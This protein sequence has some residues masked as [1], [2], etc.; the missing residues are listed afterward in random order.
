MAFHNVKKP[1]KPVENWF[2][3]TSNLGSWVRQAAPSGTGSAICF[4]QT[5]RYFSDRLFFQTG[6]KES[7]SD[8]RDPALRIRQ[9]PGTRHFGPGNV[10]GPGTSDPAIARHLADLIKDL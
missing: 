3:W 7:V 1:Y 8:A 10:P 2:F 4:F 6:L 9:C 5:D